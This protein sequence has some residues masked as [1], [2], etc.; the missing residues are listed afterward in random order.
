VLKRAI[1][2]LLLQ[3]VASAATAQSLVQVQLPPGEY[4]LFA[5]PGPA[6]APP[7]DPILSKGG[8]AT[9]PLKPSLDHIYVLDKSTGALAVERVSSDSILWKVKPSEFD[10]I[11][12]VSVA[13]QHNGQ[14]I[15]SGE[16]SLGDGDSRHSAIIDQLAPASFFDVP[17]GKLNVTVKYRQKDGTTGSLTQVFT[18]A[19]KPEGVKLSVAV[20]DDVETA[21][22]SSTEVSPTGPVGGA[23]S[24]PAPKPLGPPANPYGSAVVWLLGVGVAGFFVY[25]AMRYMKANPDAVGSKLQQLGVQVPQSG[26]AALSQGTPIMPATPLAPQPVQKIVLDNAAP[27]PFVAAP[28]MGS[29]TGQP[30]LLASSGVAIP[31]PEGETIVGREPGLGLSLSAE[32]TV[33][34]RHATLQK[35]GSEVTLT[36]LGSSNGTYVNG[37]RLQSPVVLRQGDAVQFGSAKFQYVS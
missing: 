31:L 11:A 20:A 13:V 30:S 19:A 3:C 7:P 36:D 27:E 26:D 22:S 35:M 8:A 32:T 14:P 21:G 10:R 5:S 17:A 25:F 16:V 37:A 6:L 4:A 2:L 34:R 24:G 23:S 28:A 15:S 18:A 33:S 12:N 9:V 1:L 29:P